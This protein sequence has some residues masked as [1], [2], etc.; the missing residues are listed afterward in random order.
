MLIS[1]AGGINPTAIMD[2]VDNELF[3]LEYRT[4]LSLNF[5][6]AI[7]YKSACDILI[8]DDSGQTQQIIPSL[9]ENVTFDSANHLVNITVLPLRGNYSYS[10]IVPSTC[11]TTFGNVTWFVGTNISSWDFWV[12]CLQL[13]GAVPP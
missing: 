4:Y 5:G 1:Q 10:V 3:V 11:F 12:R 8:L 7:M 13:S 9:S 2:P 6:S